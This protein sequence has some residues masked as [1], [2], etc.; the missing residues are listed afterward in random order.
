MPVVRVSGGCVGQVRPPQSSGLRR[1]LGRRSQREQL[2]LVLRILL[3]LRVDFIP[4]CGELFVDAQG[5]RL[6]R[7]AYDERHRIFVCLPEPVQLRAAIVEP[8]H[9]EGATLRCVSAKYRRSGSARS[10]SSRACWSVSKCSSHTCEVFS[11]STISRIHRW[12]ES[13]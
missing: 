8:A 13:P 2:G 1:E 4:R 10:A 7:V 3:T 11:A 9:G 5:L 12:S 6:D